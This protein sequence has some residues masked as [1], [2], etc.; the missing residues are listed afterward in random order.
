M[1]NPRDLELGGHFESTCG[2][3]KANRIFV[4]FMELGWLGTC[5]IFFERVPRTI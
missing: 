3:E 5:G 1:W 2:V 4:L